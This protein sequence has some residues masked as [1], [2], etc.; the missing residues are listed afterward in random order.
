MPLDT[1]VYDLLIHLPYATDCFPL[2]VDCISPGLSFCLERRKRGKV[3]AASLERE[4][5]E[6]VPV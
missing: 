6:N 1:S 2:F 5:E 4:E 3:E